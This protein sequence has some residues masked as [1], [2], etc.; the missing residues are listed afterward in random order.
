[1]DSKKL[2][3]DPADLE[4]ARRILDSIKIVRDYPGPGR[5]TVH[6]VS[7]RSYTIATDILKQLDKLEGAASHHIERAIRFYLTVTK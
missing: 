5:P 7:R 1:M 4:A 2:K 3:L 6:P